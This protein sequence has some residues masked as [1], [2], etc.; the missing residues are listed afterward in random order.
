VVHRNSRGGWGT[1][2][3]S[4]FF[5][6]RFFAL[7]AAARVGLQ[8]GAVWRRMLQKPLAL[9]EHFP[10]LLGFDEALHHLGSVRACGDDVSDLACQVFPDSRQL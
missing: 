6:P 2:F 4:R 3:G 5:P 1:T 7:V 8:S 9:R 10:D